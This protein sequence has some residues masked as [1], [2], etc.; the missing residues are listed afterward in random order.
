MPKRI[1]LIS[2][3]ASPMGVLG[4]VDSGGQNVYVAQVAKHLAAIGYEVDV[5]TRRDNVD[6]PQEVAWVNGV[7]I[8][9]VPAG[10]AFPIP[11]EK[12]LPCMEEFTRFFL[13]FSE[14]EGHP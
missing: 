12:I 2:E 4:G 11:K 9:N 3:H 1:A 5:F 6:L 8:I 14:S 10:P 13:E 7:R